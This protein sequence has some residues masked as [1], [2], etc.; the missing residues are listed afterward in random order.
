MEQTPILATYGNKCKV[1]S[2]SPSLPSKWCDA[3]SVPRQAI[4]AFEQ[5]NGPKFVDAST[6]SEGTSPIAPPTRPSGSIS[7]FLP[8]F[9]QVTNPL[10]LQPPRQPLK[11]HEIDE[12]KKTAVVSY[13][14]N[15]RHVISWKDLLIV[16]PEL[17]ANYLV[18][19]RLQ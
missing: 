14:T 17:F 9:A 7:S 16:N 18:A 15:E 19:T 8:S 1:L 11:I 5:Q 6:Q 13:K 2:R 12:L 10:A 4:A 3:S